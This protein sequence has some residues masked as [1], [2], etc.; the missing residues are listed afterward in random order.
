MSDVQAWAR[1][2][3]AWSDPFIA[4]IR[5]QVGFFTELNGRARDLPKGGDAPGAM[6]AWADLERAKVAAFESEAVGLSIKASTPPPLPPEFAA[7]APLQ[8]MA[9]GMAGLPKIAAERTKMNAALAREVID[10]IVASA[11]GDARARTALQSKTFEMDIAIFD[12]E[13]ALISAGAAILPETSPERDLAQ[14]YIET[15]A[16]RRELR[17]FA[18]AASEGQ[19]GQDRAALAAA[20]RTHADRMMAAADG[21]DR[22]LDAA[23][24]EM[25]AASADVRGTPMF[26]IMT[27][28]IDSYR[29]SGVVQRQLADRLKSLADYVQDP[30]VTPAQA[31]AREAT[32]NDLLADNEALVLERRKLIGG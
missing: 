2:G 22:S 7:Y 15:N 32:L 1:Q 13:D 9:D 28:A 25:G 30:A 5:G 31:I 10:L 3:K 29:R 17:R 6:K 12:T 19:A 23:A 8:R 24:A 21:L 26:G 27:K 14:C 11:N 4:L 16:V 18:L 20:I